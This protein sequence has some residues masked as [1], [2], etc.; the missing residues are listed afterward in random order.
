ML[1]NRARAEEKMDKYDLEALVATSPANVFYFSDCYPYGKCYALLPRDKNIKPVLI[2][3]ISGSTPIV[4]MSPPWF[5][6]ARYYG[7][8][9]IYTQFIDHPVD[10]S[11]E[12]LVKAVENGEYTKQ[13]APEKIL[14]DL[15]REKGFEGKIGIDES[16][17]KYED[18]LIRDLTTSNS[19]VEAV[20]A[21]QV[22]REIRMVKTG[23]EIKRIE[24]AIK[25]TQNAWEKSLNNI[26]EGIT[27]TEFAEI[28][29]QTILKKGGH[30]FT[31]LGR[32]W[33]PIAF[34]RRTAFSDIAQPTNY[35]LK[36]GD[37][38]RFDGGCTYQGYPCDMARVASYGKPSEKLQSYW[39]AIYAGEQAAIELVKPGVKA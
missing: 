17:L 4:L 36:K 10:A 1:V 11:E 23:E 20:P 21:N 33:P 14:S 8:F 2:A 15:I 3:P 26:E 12:R 32:Y 18:P 24:K 27:E 35:Q 29:Q 7:E 13:L 30:N 28:F 25:I 22:I 37:M 31:Y 39:K 38:I 34:G 5:D 6:D 19:N 9:Y 16:G